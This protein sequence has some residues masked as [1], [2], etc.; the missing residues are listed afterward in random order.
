[1]KLRFILA[2]L[3]AGAL[4]PL[5]AAAEFGGTTT[6]SFGR[7]SANGQDLNNAAPAFDG[8]Y[9][10][11]NN[12]VLDFG[13]NHNRLS[14]PGAGGGLARSS[15]GRLGAMYGF[16]TFGVGAYLDVF[17]IDLTGTDLT[18]KSYG[19]KAAYMPGTYEIGGFVG[20]SKIEQLGTTIDG[21]DYGLTFKVER[22][23]F[24]VFGTIQRTNVDSGGGPQ[25]L[26]GYGLGGAFAFSDSF[27]LFAGARQW[28]V[29]GTSDVANS[30][31]LGAAYTFNGVSS[32][33]V[34]VGLEYSRLGGDLL[35]GGDTINVYKL[36]VSIPIGNKGPVVPV[37][38][39]AGDIRSPL[40]SSFS[41]LYASVY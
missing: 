35:A 19:L 22:P 21:K 17:T 13:L 2:A 25:D 15:S 24:S 1:M 20:A 36:S 11:G 40:R 14:N 37:D 39:V 26:T 12:V 28:Q 41:S 7:L 4:T 3:A 10:F 34:S 27:S 29:S 31:G 5:P 16:G 32:V 18:I 33:P 23:K 38:S 6:L 30:I 9:S 8:W